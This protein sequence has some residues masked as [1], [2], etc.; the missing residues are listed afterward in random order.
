MAAYVDRARDVREVGAC[1]GGEA[2]RQ[3]ILGEERLSQRGE[4]WGRCPRVFGACARVYGDLYAKVCDD[5]VCGP[6]AIARLERR[7]RLDLPSLAMRSMYG[8]CKA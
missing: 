8:G 5:L 1:C 4:A 3:G 7:E 6:A 2:R